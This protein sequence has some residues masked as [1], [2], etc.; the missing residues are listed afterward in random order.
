MS[1]LEKY[2]M[3]KIVFGLMLFLAFSNADAQNIGTKE[4]LKPYKLYLKSPDFLELLGK[5]KQPQKDSTEIITFNNF[6]DSK[7]FF[8][9]SNNYLICSFDVEEFRTRLYKDEWGLNEYTE[10]ASYTNYVYQNQKI[11]YKSIRLKKDLKEKVIDIKH[12]NRDEEVIDIY[13]YQNG[14]PKQLYSKSAK[15]NWYFDKKGNIINSTD[16][17]AILKEEEKKEEEKKKFVLDDSKFTFEEHKKIREDLSKMIANTDITGKGLDYFSVSDWELQNKVKKYLKKI[18]KTDLDLYI[19]GMTIGSII[20]FSEY[21]D[22]Y[23]LEHYRKEYYEEDEE[24]RKYNK[25]QDI[26]KNKK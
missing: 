13:Y 14:K 23:E 20:L 16:Y 4:S 26:E 22:W 3:K 15:T 17:Y 21:F 5:S 19:D 9:N 24:M 7:D 1:V 25:S 11:V 18:F 6:S 8:R 2:F 10:L 12:Y